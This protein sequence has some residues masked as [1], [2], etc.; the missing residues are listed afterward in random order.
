MTSQRPD[1]ESNGARTLARAAILAHVDRTAEALAV[2]NAG[3]FD[4]PLEVAADLLKARLLAATDIEACWATYARALAREPN[5]V[6]LNLRA[7]V[8]AYERGDL[9]HARTLLERSW[10]L[11]PL[12]E[13]GLYLGK[14]YAG[15]GDGERALRHLVQALALDHPHGQWQQFVA[16]ELGSLMRSA[17]K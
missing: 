15:H 6:V 13:T 3:A 7:G 4:P 12:P 1:D 9:E 16:S 5:H 17:R 11:A 10:S 14:I 2:L 8:F